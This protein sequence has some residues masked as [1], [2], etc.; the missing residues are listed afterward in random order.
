MDRGSNHIPRGVASINAQAVKPEIDTSVLLAGAQFVDAYRIAVGA[1]IHDAR[2]AAE[3]MLGRQPRWIT[4][5]MVVRNCVVAPFGLKTPVPEQ[6]ASADMI[7]IFPVLSA[8]PDRLVAGFDDRHL[9]FRVI[10]EVARTNLGHRV[11]TTTL[12]RTHNLLGRVYLAVVLPFHR[13][14]VRSM[15]RQLARTS[16]RQPA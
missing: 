2:L 11:T 14:I 9:D 8:S 1:A 16:H 12:V 7:G 15:L 10:V 13:I 6:T 3:H 5:L 4:G